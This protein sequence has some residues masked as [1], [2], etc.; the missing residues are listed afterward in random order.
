MPFLK[1]WQ[2]VSVG[3]LCRDHYQQEEAEDILRTYASLSLRPL[4]III[5]LLLIWYYSSMRNFASLPD[6]SQSA[7]FNDLSFQPV[8]LHLLTSVCANIRHLFFL[9]SS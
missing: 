5:L 8:I 2:W 7:L 3:Q 9:S 4:D 1:G 6:T